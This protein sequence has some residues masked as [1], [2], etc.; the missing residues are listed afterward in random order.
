MTGPHGGFDERY[1]REELSDAPVEA[2]FNKDRGS[3]LTPISDYVKGLFAKIKNIHDVFTS[4]RP[5]FEDEEFEVCFRSSDLQAPFSERKST[6]QSERK[7]TL[8][9]KL[10]YVAD[11]LLSQTF[12]AVDAI[13]RATEIIAHTQVGL[14]VPSVIRKLDPST[15][16]M[17]G[18]LY[19]FS[20]N[21]LLNF[22]VINCIN[23]PNLSKL[24]NLQ[25]SD[26][27]LRNDEGAITYAYTTRSGQNPHPI[28]F[29]E[30]RSIGQTGSATTIGMFLVIDAGNDAGNAVVPYVT[31]M[32]KGNGAA[33]E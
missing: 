28:T 22:R 10:E 16:I 33:L 31:P 17:P 13:G 21:A 26:V 8:F 5:A 14:S 2:V 3:S 15:V 4:A 24:R 20:S 1:T 19:S 29:Q 18:E 9:N 12:T 11:I 32:Y 27:P 25:K 30:G 7:Q 23:R 6:V